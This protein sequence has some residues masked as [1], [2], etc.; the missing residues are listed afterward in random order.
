MRISFAIMS[1]LVSVLFLNSCVK[2]L[3]QVDLI[4]TNI[5]IIDAEDG[6]RTNQTVVILGNK[7]EWIGDASQQLNYIATKTVDGSGKYLIPGLWDAHVHLTYEPELGL[8]IYDLLLANG[9]TSIRDTGGYLDELEPY[10][11]KAA[12]DSINVPRI[13][14]A[15]PLL[16]GEPV[17]YDRANPGRPGLGVAVPSIEAAKTQIDRLDSAGVDLLKAYELLRPDVYL[18]LMQYAKE[19][20]LIV[21]GHIPLSMDLI[22]ASN[23]G[24]RSVEHLRN[25]EMACATDAEELLLMRNQLLENEEGLKGYALRSKIHSAQ[26]NYAI[27]N[28]DPDRKKAVFEALRRNNTWQVP[29]LTILASWKNRL[30]E[31]E[32][33]VATF[34][35]LPENMKA[36]WANLALEVTALPIDS[37]KIEFADWGFR[38]VKEL[39]DAK[40][41]LMAG[42]DAPIF[43]LTPGFSLHKEL[44][45]LANCGLSNLEVLASATT[46]PA[47]YFGMQAELGTIESGKLADLVILNADPL[48][49]IANTQKIEAVI[50]NGYLHDRAALDQKLQQ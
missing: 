18:G 17:V 21:T 25:L 12:E 3:Q 27:Q 24:L 15:G 8:K 48:L 33:W 20:D 43:L 29:T 39:S 40:V 14:V 47:E 5:S 30:F 10:R 7:I 23:A 34:D 32:E 11:V 4:I 9:V 46:K 35:Y 28:E 19:K 37:N 26:R 41:G 42:T 13:K 1:L 16:D 50:R 31:N 45:L 6:K 44:K 49:D 38:T 36:R 22:E 2:D